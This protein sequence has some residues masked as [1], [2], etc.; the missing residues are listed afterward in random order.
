M[1]NVLWWNPSNYTNITMTKILSTFFLLTFGNCTT[2]SCHFCHDRDYKVHFFPHFF[3]QHHQCCWQCSLL[4]TSQ[5]QPSFS[6]LKSNP[7]WCLLDSMQMR[8]CEL[9]ALMLKNQKPKNIWNKRSN[10]I[11]F[12]KIY[13]PCVYFLDTCLF[14]I[15]LCY[16]SFIWSIALIRQKT[17]VH[18]SA[19]KVLQHQGLT[20]SVT[21]L[22]LLHLRA[23][24]DSSVSIGSITRVIWNSSSTSNGK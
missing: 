9:L 19:R 10:L 24:H 12:C 22:Q 16:S 20:G 13:I 3:R 4:A 11:V 23:C 14:S 6:P 2:S 1:K 7:S 5:K 18:H 8:H 21:D 17:H 15:M